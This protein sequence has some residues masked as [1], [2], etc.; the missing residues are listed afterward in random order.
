MQE[1]SRHLHIRKRV[2]KHIERY[3]HPV[4]WKRYLDWLMYFIGIVTP[5]VLVPQ[6]LE[7]WFYK[8]TAGVSVSTWFL[9]ALINILWVFYGVVHGAKAVIVSNLIMSILNFLVAAGALV[10]Q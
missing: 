7:V 9:F 1:G 3:P 8:N 4:R 6:L 5:L 2:Y 10:L